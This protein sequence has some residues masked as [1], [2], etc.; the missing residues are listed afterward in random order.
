M[1][2]NKIGVGIVTY[3]SEDYFKTLYESLPLARI[4]ELVVVNGGN[5]YRENYACHW[6]QHNTNC[7]PAICRN[8][9]VNFL[10]NRGCEHIFLIE[11]DMIIKDPNIFEKYI[12]SSEVSGL[13]YFSYVSTSWESGE[14]GNR[15][16]R[17]TIEY[18][19][20]VSI[21]FF[22]NM[23]NEFT[24]HH[25]TAFEDTGLYDT[26][27]RD[28]FDI[29][30]AYR[31]SQQG[32]AAPFWWFADVTGSDNLICNNPVAV[33]R[34][35]GDRPDGSRAQRIE[36]QWKLFIAKHGTF[37]SQIP[38]ITKD[39]VLQRLIMRGKNYGK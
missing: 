17:L 9:A 15:T 30:M 35:Q 33:S 29:D 18:T 23:C 20:E 12:K 32:H 7:Y 25:Y 6:I 10:M 22:K 26:Q 1:E 13:K 21:S 16:P 14:P 36:E 19:P 31:E 34:L 38:D 4:N 39:K 2:K 5:H 11:D 3:N 8:D 37:V 24:Y 28:P 27:F